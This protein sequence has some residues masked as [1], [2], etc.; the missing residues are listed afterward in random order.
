MAIESPG[1]RLCRIHAYEIERLLPTAVFCSRFQAQFLHASRKILP[2][3]FVAGTART[4]TLIPV[5]ADLHDDAAHVVTRYLKSGL[6]SGRITAGCLCNHCGCG[7]GS[8]GH[9]LF[10]WRLLGRARPQDSGDYRNKSQLDFFHIY[11]PGLV[12]DK[13]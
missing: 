9:C 2:G 11:S 3:C 6:L 10:L 5:I 7:L 13:Y 12:P 1:I 8:F 4:A